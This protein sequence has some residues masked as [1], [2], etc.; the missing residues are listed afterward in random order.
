M[1]FELIILCLK[2]D[3]YGF[4]QEQQPK[5]LLSQ[6]VKREIVFDGKT[7]FYVNFHHSDKNVL[8]IKEREKKSV[9]RKS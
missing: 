3:A 7:I 2:C 9:E 6:F 4:K 8:C 5:Q 1:C